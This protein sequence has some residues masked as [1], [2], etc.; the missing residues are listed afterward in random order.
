MSGNSL[1]LPLSLLAIIT[2]GV[3]FYS[4]THV[5]TVSAVDVQQLPI[6][7]YFAFTG[8]NS[9][10]KYDTT[11]YVKTSNDKKGVIQV[12]GTVG[13]VSGPGPGQ[14]WKF[15]STDPSCKNTSFKLVYNGSSAEV[16][17]SGLGNIDKS[18]PLNGVLND[19]QRLKQIP[20]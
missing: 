16:I 6:G 9:E 10:N 8:E 2:G 3:I 17:L 12:G 20:E 4:L 14:I 11:I 1:A 5:K 15:R 19:G 18:C 7:K 13:D